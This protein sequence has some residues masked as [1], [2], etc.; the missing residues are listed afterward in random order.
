MTADAVTS[1]VMQQIAL[2]AVGVL[3]RG[4]PRVQQTQGGLLLF[5]EGQ[6]RDH[7]DCKSNHQA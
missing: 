1:T 5:I 6:Q 2:K 7:K 4:R 3:V